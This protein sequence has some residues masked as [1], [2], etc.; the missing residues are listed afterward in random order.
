MED[1]LA[2]LRLKGIRVL[3]YLD[4]WLICAQAPAQAEAHME[5]VT[6]H[7]QWLGLALNHE[8]SHLMAS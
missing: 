5:L 7:L 4:V 1:I 2:P 6:G 3:K 8:K